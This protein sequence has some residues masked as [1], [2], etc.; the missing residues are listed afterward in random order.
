MSCAESTVRYFLVQQHC[1]RVFQ[2]HTKTYVLI[3]THE[4]VDSSS[5]LRYCSK[6]NHVSNSSIYRMSMKL[7]M[8]LRITGCSG[9]KSTREDV[10]HF[11]QAGQATFLALDVFVS[12]IK[13]QLRVRTQCG[14]PPR[15]Y[16]VKF[17]H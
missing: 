12:L 13:A 4:H 8:L 10:C 3:N 6:I 5:G 15:A 11:F 17:M 1:V 9:A 2:K 7:K 14:T 16:D